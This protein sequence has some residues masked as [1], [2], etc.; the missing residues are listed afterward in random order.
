[1][2]IIKGHNKSSDMTES[3]LFIVAGLIASLIGILTFAYAMFQWRRSISL[4]W[5]KA[6]ARSKKNRKKSTRILQLLMYG[7]WN[8]LL[9]PKDLTVAYV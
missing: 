6:I 9:V 3:Q 1:M 5:M 4:S 7:A 2:L 8:R